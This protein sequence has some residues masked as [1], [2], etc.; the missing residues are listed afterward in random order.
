[1]VIFKLLLL[2]RIVFFSGGMRGYF[3]ITDITTSIFSRVA[4]AVIFK[5]LLQRR[6]FFQVACAVI[7]KITTTPTS[8]CFPGGVRGNF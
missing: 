8:N 1:M 6:V 4:C 7:F 2:P 3:E 5:L